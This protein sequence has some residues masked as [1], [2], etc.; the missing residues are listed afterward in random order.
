MAGVILDSKAVSVVG[1]S[2]FAAVGA[3]AVNQIYVCI[4][5]YICCDISIHL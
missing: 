5:I 1:A 3:G 2:L 4:C